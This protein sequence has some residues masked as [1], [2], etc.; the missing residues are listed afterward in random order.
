MEKTKNLTAAQRLEGLEQAVISLDNALRNTVNT[1]EML[2][3]AIK[4]LGNKI[5]AVVKVERA[6]GDLTDEAISDMMVQNNV[7]ELKQKVSDM[8]NSG[9]LVL[10]E[11]AKE[12]SFVAG[13]E[14]DPETKKVQNPRIQIA[15]SALKQE[16]RNLV[17]GKKAGDTVDFG[18]DKLSIELEEVYDIVT[19][20][21][22]NA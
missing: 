4:I 18:K 19:Q 22:Q 13:R 6:G 1:Q 11:E 7:Q 10:T 15:L 14:I 9:L 20:S 16:A 3:Q 8:V 21:E 17:L 12:N 5:D 2:H